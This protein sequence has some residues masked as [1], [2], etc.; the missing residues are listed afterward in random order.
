[1]NKQ[2]HISALESIRDG[3]LG[4]NLPVN[5]IFCENGVHRFTARQWY[6]ADGYRSVEDYLYTL[7]DGVLRVER[8]D[9][10]LSVLDY[11]LDFN[12]LEELA[13]QPERRPY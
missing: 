9:C 3:L 1:M 5:P 6:S 13:I 7:R 2:S 10:P 4:F 11:E 8:I 12:E